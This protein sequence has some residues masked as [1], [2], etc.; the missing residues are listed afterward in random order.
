MY[1]RG[2]NYG[3]IWAASGALGFFGE[4]YWY[5]RFI[6]SLDGLTFVG[7]TVTLDPNEGN[8]PLSRDTWQPKM[9]FPR[10]IRFD[11]FKGIALNAVGLSNFG[12]AEAL[13]TDKWQERQEP[14]FISFMPL[15][16]TKEGRLI[17]TRQYVS[18]L[19][20]ALPWFRGKVALQVNL[21]CPNTGENLKE[22]ENEAIEILKILTEL[23]I[24]LV[25]KFNVLTSPSTVKRIAREVAIDAVCVSNTLPYGTLPQ[26]VDWHKLFGDASPLAHLGGGG[27]SGKIL[28]PLVLNWVKRA[29]ADGLELPIN[30]GG[31]IMSKGQPTLLFAAG[32][33]SVSIG[34]VIM[35]RPYRVPALIAETYS[36]V[37]YP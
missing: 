11:P 34:T 25:P 10:C 21:S 32:A 6:P 22:L 8:M 24:P 33:Q 16:K 36:N 37:G 9:P 7:K 29:R 27:L 1:L 35:L 2:I 5:H 4:G 12:I 31:G 15:S 18:Y 23:G 28:F 13:R 17:E 3:P 14:F 26:E 20:G 30:A 19:K